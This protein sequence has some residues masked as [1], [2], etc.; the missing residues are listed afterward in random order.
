MS[1][2]SNYLYQERFHVLFMA[3][4]FGDFKICYSIDTEEEISLTKTA[5]VQQNPRSQIFQTEIANFKTF[6]PI[7]LTVDYSSQSNIEF[8]TTTKKATHYQGDFSMNGRTVISKTTY[9]ILT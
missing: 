3:V 1:D 9:T 8:K 2:T 5:T 4:R 7:V 6:P